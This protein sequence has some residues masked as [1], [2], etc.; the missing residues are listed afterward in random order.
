M[1]PHVNDKHGLFLWEDEVLLERAIRHYIEANNADALQHLLDFRPCHG[2]SSTPAIT[3]SWQSA[4]PSLLVICLLPLF[5]LDARLA[6]E[7]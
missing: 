7:A 4:L 5:G 6:I 1:T 2:R 3:K